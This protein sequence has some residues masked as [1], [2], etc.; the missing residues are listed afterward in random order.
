MNIAATIPTTS[1]DSVAGSESSLP[2]DPPGA[3]SI[4]ALRPGSAALS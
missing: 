2:I 4:P 3:T 1:L